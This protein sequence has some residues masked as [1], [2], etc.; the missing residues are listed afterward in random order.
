MLPDA[1]GIRDEHLREDD[2]AIFDLS[3]ALRSANASDLPS[4]LRERARV[5]VKRRL[6]SHRH[7]IK[8]N[9]ILN[10]VKDLKI[11]NRFPSRD[12][13]LRSG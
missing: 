7:E 4:P 5:R 6:S 2:E 3:R 13:S 1:R 9:V 10:E 11:E 12:P 8:T